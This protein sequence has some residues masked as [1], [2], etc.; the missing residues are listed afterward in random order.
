MIAWDRFTL[1][2]SGHRRGCIFCFVTLVRWHCFGHCHYLLVGFTHCGWCVSSILG[3]KRWLEVLE[4]GWTLL[5]LFPVTTL[6]FEWLSW[7]RHRVVNSSVATFLFAQSKRPIGYILSA[8]IVFFIGLSVFVTYMAGR[9]EIRQ[10]IWHEQAGIGSSLERVAG[11]F[12]GFSW[13]DLSN[14]Q[15][16]DA[17]KSRL[18]QDVLVG[19]AVDRLQR[20]EVEYASGGTLSK[21]VLSLIPRVVWPDKPIV[22]G[23]G[24]V[25]QDFTEIVFA[26]G[27]SVGAGQVLEFYVNFGT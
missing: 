11:T 1:N 7:L 24:S 6:I 4:Y 13:L 25:V 26:E 27:T 10:T 9:D 8:P 3:G 16:R 5:P 12:R 17:L 18:N 19:T 22:G 21:M 2:L 14:L 23:G 15:H 20:G